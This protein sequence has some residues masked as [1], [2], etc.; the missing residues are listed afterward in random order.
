MTNEEL[1]TEARRWPNPNGGEP[2][3]APADLIGRLADAL[4]AVPR[5]NAP[6]RAA[7]NRDKKA[8]GGLCTG[9]GAFCQAE[10]A[11]FQCT[12]G[13]GHDGPHV[14]CGPNEH[15]YTHAVCTTYL[16]VGGDDA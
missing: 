2:S 14:E 7:E 10:F 12:R 5:K 9:H 6:A 8:C 1:I 11:G 15:D 16:T 3:A 4:E 13:K